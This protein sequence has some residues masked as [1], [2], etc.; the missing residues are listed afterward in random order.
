[1]TVW[2]VRFLQEEV[3]ELPASIFNGGEDGDAGTWGHRGRR[4]VAKERCYIL[5]S[6]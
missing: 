3:H 5:S 6:K 4:R 1:M 2:S